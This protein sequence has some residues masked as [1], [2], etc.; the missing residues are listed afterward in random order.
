MCNNKYVPLVT[1][2]GEIEKYH[3]LFSFVSARVGG[4]FIMNILS[5]L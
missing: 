4:H 2:A 1:H 3:F 5:Y